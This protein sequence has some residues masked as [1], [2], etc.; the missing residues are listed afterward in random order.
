MIKYCIFL[1]F[2]LN[3]KNILI[4]RKSFISAWIP[5]FGKVVLFG[6]YTFHGIDKSVSRH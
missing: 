1:I 2:L 3:F 4:T 5:T 6:D